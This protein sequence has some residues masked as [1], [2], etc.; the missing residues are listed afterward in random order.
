MMK[1]FYF[2]PLFAAFV[3]QTGLI[4]QPNKANQSKAQL[5]VQIQKLPSN[6]E[7]NYYDTSAPPPQIERPYGQDMNKNTRV[8]IQSTQKNGTR[9]NVQNDA[10]SERTLSILK[11]DALKNK[12]IGDII[13]RFEKE[14]LRVV[15]IK[16][17]KLSPE[18]A[19]QFYKVH[20]DRPFFNN[21]VQYMSSGPVVI[22]VLEGNQ[23]ISKNRALMGATDPKKAEKGTIRADFAQSMTENAVHGSDSPEAAQEEILFFFRPQEIFSEPNQK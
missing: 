12:H 18:Q 14:G 8:E 4:A 21:L 9:Q 7:G 5:D 2:L 11:P 19:G 6:Q 1:I 20:R 16:M 23:A 13:S 22:L 17:T 10:K 15:A 3:L